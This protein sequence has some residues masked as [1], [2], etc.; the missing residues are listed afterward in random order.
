MGSIKKGRRPLTEADIDAGRVKI[1][2]AAKSLFGQKG[3]QSVSMRA[4]AEVADMSAMSIY[5]YYEN[6]RAILLHIWAEVFTQL[7]KDCRTA[8]AQAREPADAVKAYAISFVDYWVNNP[9]NYLMIYGEIDTPVGG[10]S[11]FADSEEVA[12]ELAFIAGLIVASGTP[13]S[14]IE[15]T[16]QQLICAMHGVC[17]SLITIP[18]LRWRPSEA[19]ISG[20]VDALLRR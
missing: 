13:E 20:L 19:L 9:E 10:E 11:F 12:T 8:S 18:E 14:E 16:L 7:F 4:V 1:L 5:R 17:H 15:L 2:A 3:Y 6:K